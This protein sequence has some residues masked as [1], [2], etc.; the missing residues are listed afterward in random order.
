MDNE[1]ASGKAHKIVT[2]ETKDGTS[3]IIEN[4]IFKLMTKDH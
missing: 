4:E 1:L 3:K 2:L